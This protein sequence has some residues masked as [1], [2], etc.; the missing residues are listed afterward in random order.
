MNYVNEDYFIYDYDCDFYYY[1]E[2]NVDVDSDGSYNIDIYWE[3]W[4]TS[5]YEH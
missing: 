1:Y 4:I 5:F 2:C 3:E